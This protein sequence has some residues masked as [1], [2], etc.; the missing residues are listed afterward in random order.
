M[1]VRADVIPGPAKADNRSDQCISW[2]TPYLAIINDFRLILNE[3]RH[4]ETAVP[5]DFRDSGNQKRC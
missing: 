1:S 2:K 5:R 4:E 3:L